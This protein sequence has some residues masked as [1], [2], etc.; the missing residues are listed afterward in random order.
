MDQKVTLID[1]KSHQGIE[2]NASGK[3]QLSAQNPSVVQLKISSE[4]IKEYK[5]EGNN[6][7]VVLKSGELITIMGFFDAD[8][9]LVLQDDV[10]H[11]L[12]WVEF[13]SNEE[14]L[15]ATYAE[16]NDVGPLLYGEND[17]ASPW[18]WAAVPLTAGGIL[19]WAG[20]DSGNDSD[21]GIGETNEGPSAPESVVI[22]NGDEWI[23]ADEI[24][25]DGKV[26]VTIDLPADAVAGDSVIVN[27]EETV[28]TADDI[29]AGEIIV[30]VDSPNEGETL[31][32]EVSI[33]DAAGNESDEIL[34]E[35]AVDS[36]LPVVEIEAITPIDSDNPADGVADQ[37]LITGT[38]DEPNEGMTD[39]TGAFSATVDT[40][41]VQAGDDVTVEVTDKAGNTGTD[42]ATAGDLTFST[43]TT[44]PVVEIEAVT[45]IDSDNPA[46]GVADQ[47]L[48]TG[49]SD[50]PNAPVE[51][52]DKAGNTIWEG[53]TDGTG[54]FSATVDTAAVQAG[55]DVTV[56]VTDKAGNTGT[57]TA[58][59]GDL[60]FTNDPLVLENDSA[61]AVYQESQVN[62]NPIGELTSDT[63]IK[64]LAGSSAT[65][66]LEFSIANGAQDVVITVKSESLVTVADAYS[67]TVINKETGQE[68]TVAASST[69]QGGLVAGALGLEALGVVGDD[70]NGLRLDIHDLP[71]GD[72]EVVVQGDQSKLADIL[73]TVSLEDLGSN[74]VETLILDTVTGL[75]KDA[76]IG[77]E[78]IAVGLLNQLSVEQLLNLVEGNPNPLVSGLGSTLQA[79]LANPLLAL[80]LGGITSATVGEI[81]EGDIDT[82]VLGL[83]NNIPFVGPD[84]VQPLLNAVGGLVDG[85]V[86]NLDSIGEDLFNLVIEPLIADVL[87]AGLIDNLSLNDALNGLLGSIK[88][89]LN[90][91]G[92]GDLLPALDDVLQL[93]AQEILSNPAQLFNEVNAAVYGVDEKTY[94]AEGNVLANDEVVNGSIIEVNGVP[95]T[96]NQTDV[97]GNYA[98]ITGTH[99]TLHLYEDGHYIYTSTVTSGNATSVVDDFTY[100]VQ[101]EY[102][103]T[104][105]AVLTIT[106][107]PVNETIDFSG[108]ASDDML[109][110]GAGDDI[111]TGG[112]GADTAIYYLLDNA[113]AT[114]GNGTDTWSDFELGADADKIDISA[115]LD[116]LQTSANIGDYI[117]VETN[118]DG[119][120]V[121]SI[122]RDGVSNGFSASDLLVLD[123]ISPADLNLTN[124]ELLNNLL[125]NNQIVY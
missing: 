23:T 49:T 12:L 46:D 19:A 60:I 61:N 103:N 51:I 102:N 22:G 27:G 108:T 32:V 28:L 84:L 124:D 55:D 104:E 90:T 47:V 116:G 38:S 8:N 43:D 82:G 48:I 37:V 106:T 62:P 63:A 87:L 98:I 86:D 5:K 105:D 94:V 123:N 25:A 14:S 39:G 17:A 119:K 79:V 73:S 15:S 100:T 31:E 68:Y 107:D 120:A 78:N 1:K 112:A 95:I 93:V 72:Y 6:L 34:A 36:V 44:E 59:A 24:D 56:E 111:L 18:A 97:N 33:K 74:T 77:N 13:S 21:K 85:V 10:N 101:D 88:D 121:I 64:L 3:I 113:D 41:A 16:L 42:T 11:K 89:L 99:G 50:E 96:F 110:G 81:L 30:K 53:M 45:P 114:G 7:V 92:A 58:T 71:P 70:G 91:V 57:D 115:L 80:V 76:L 65:D 118:A 117:S 75:L 9:S 67:F 83:I 66:K 109:Q 52:K 29:T 20:H 2:V 125:S 26:D 35:A 4:D 69:A 40:A 54:A 122:D